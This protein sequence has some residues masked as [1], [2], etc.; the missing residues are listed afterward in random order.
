MSHNIT[1]EGGTSVRLPTAGK[2]CDR[3][4]V[5]T[6]TGN[7]A[8]VT[9]QSKTVTPSKSTQ[10]VKADAGYTGLEKVT[11][12]PIPS[13]YIIPSGTKTITENGT[14]DAAAYA[15][16]SVNV[17]SKTPVLQEKT[18][19]PATDA[20]AVTA[21]SG[22]DGLSKV[23]VNAMPTAVQALPTITVDNSGL[24]LATAE[25]QAGYVVA[26][27]RT[28]MKQ[29]T[30]QAGKTVTPSKS[31]QTVVESGRYTTGEVKVA[32][33]PD[34][35]IQPSG[36]LAITE[37]GTHDV[38]QYASVNVNVPSSGGGGGDS[39]LPS[40]CRR[41]DYIQFTGEQTV[42]TG[43]ICNQNTKIQLAFTRERSTQ[44]YL[45][46][47]ASSNNTAS[48]TA[49]M[50]GSWRFGNKSATK[51]PTTNA[52]M[53]YSGLVDKSTVTI[54]G[55]ASAISSVNDFETIG[56]LL[57][58]ACRNSSGTVGSSQFEGKI[59]FFSM[60]EG[61]EQVLKLVPVVDADGNFHFYDTISQQPFDSITDIP[62]GGGNF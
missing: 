34:S 60:W 48:V 43:I 12:S 17:P 24:I 6:A 57:L 3:D 40:G 21:D 44:H 59:F 7:A 23:T 22:Y 19:T 41:V 62:L 35:Y 18:V 55:S 42:D 5:I 28:G 31:E 49:Y 9:L 8:E 33:I 37:N 47:V 29:L 46:G 39:G 52:D 30:T 16:V 20:Q 61:D 11:V 25:Q 4:I 53:I 10:E 54:T 15:S 27:T 32:A 56:S 38:T 26:G 2:Y 36:S 51:V 13:E 58:G 1:V 45:Y 14:H 50:G